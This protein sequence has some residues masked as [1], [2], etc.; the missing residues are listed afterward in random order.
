MKN[1]AKSNWP[2]AMRLFCISLF[3]MLFSACATTTPGKVERSYSGTVPYAQG[4]IMTY[5]E[6]VSP[7][8][9]EIRAMKLRA[10]ELDELDNYGIDKMNGG[11]LEE[12]VFPEILTLDE[13]SL[14][15]LNLEGPMSGLGMHIQLRKRRLTNV[16]RK[17]KFIRSYNKADGSLSHKKQY[18]EEYPAYS[19]YEWSKGKMFVANDTL[20][21][22]ITPTSGEEK[23]FQ[24][25][26]AK[27]DESGKLF[28]PFY[29]WLDI[30][31]STKEG[32][33]LELV[34]E[35]YDLNTKILITQEAFKV[36]L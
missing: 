22:R 8:G 33:Q 4:K 28:I 5:I 26:T 9:A 24:Q 25:F 35:K 21:V 23:R 7:P 19:Y 1:I 18:T 15:T 16:K 29:P 12:L 17:Y 11:V 36:L 3:V 14:K 6:C 2:N 13:E 30:G 10:K 32:V 27:M 31:S 34:S 20:L